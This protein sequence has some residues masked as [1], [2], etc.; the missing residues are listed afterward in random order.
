M[1]HEFSPR[2][3]ALILIVALALA[4]LQVA[5]CSAEANVRETTWGALCKPVLI[6]R[7]SDGS[8]RLIEPAEGFLEGV[9][10][11]RVE[12]TSRVS[13]AIGDVERELLLK[14]HPKDVNTQGN[15]GIYGMKIVDRT[16]FD[17]PDHSIFVDE[18]ELKMDTTRF[19]DG[20][21]TI[22][23]LYLEDGEEVDS[24]TDEFY[25]DNAEEPLPEPTTATWIPT[26]TTETEPT[27]GQVQT[28]AI[29]LLTSI[30]IASIVVYLLFSRKRSIDRLDRQE[31]GCEQKPLG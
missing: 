16:I 21:Y 7:T 18:Y 12:H 25:F 8:I 3:V 4:F 27:N 10:T 22:E 11:F 9:V 30:A 6:D 5:H 15:T 31:R 24:I 17:L 20:L 13:G 26:E 14:V 28:Q 23:I 2:L 19:Q 29:T 1:T